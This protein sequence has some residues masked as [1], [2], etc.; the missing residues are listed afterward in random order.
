LRDGLQIGPEREY[1]LECGRAILSGVSRE[2]G[3]PPPEGLHWG[4]VYH[5]AKLA[6]LLPQLRYCVEAH[7]DQVAP[8]IWDALQAKTDAI[9][10]KNRTLTDEL[11]ELLV[12]FG[13]QGC[14]ILPYKGPVLAALSYGDIRLRQFSDLDVLIPREHMQQA[15]GYLQKRGYTLRHRTMQAADAV[16]L[17][18][19]YHYI[20]DSADGGIP[21][22][23]HGEATPCYFSFPLTNEDLWSRR[24]P[25]LVEGREVTSISR[26]DMALLLAMHGTKHEWQCLELALGLAGLLKASPSMRWDVL[27][28]RATELGARRILLLSMSLV[29]SFFHYRPPE[30]IRREVEA[31]GMV[32]RLTTQVWEYYAEIRRPGISAT[33]TLR[34][35]SRSRERLGDKLHYWTFKLFAP[36]WEEVEWLRL[37]RRLFPLYWLLRPFRLVVHYGPELLGLSEPRAAARQCRH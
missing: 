17:K 24:E 25:A 14:P 15:A 18:T 29:E 36:N 35:H 4:R 2:Q 8:E 10:A 21:V 27:L 1:V 31:D 11:F 20:F 13:R 28:D 12:G 32:K 22:E 30:E 9:A 3:V 19:E 26:E 6:R 34:F 5:T 33:Q 37:P 23:L 16:H 7:A